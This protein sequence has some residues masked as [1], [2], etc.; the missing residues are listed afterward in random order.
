[1]PRLRYLSTPGFKEDGTTPAFGV[2]GIEEPLPDD[3]LAR[4]YRDHADY[5]ERFSRRVDELVAER[6][7]LAEDA[8]EM[9]K[10]AVDAPVP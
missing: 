8:D 2:V 10:E 4:L 7:L 5:V 3:V 1:V 6:W 9:R